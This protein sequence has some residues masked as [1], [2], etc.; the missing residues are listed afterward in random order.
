MKMDEEDGAGKKADPRVRGFLSDR[1][2][3]T[4]DRRGGC[5]RIEAAPVFACMCVRA[6][7][8]TRVEEKRELTLAGRWPNE[9]SPVLLKSHSLPVVARRHRVSTVI[10]KGDATRGRGVAAPTTVCRHVRRHGA[11]VDSLQIK[12]AYAWRATVTR[13]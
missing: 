6:C 5:L 11:Y 4:V 7:V 2:T 9:A 10:E 8:S 13:L 1:D 3:R 12:I